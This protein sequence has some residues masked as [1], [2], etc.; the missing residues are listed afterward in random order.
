MEMM[1]KMENGRWK[2]SVMPGQSTFWSGK[3]DLIVRKVIFIFSAH[4]LGTTHTHVWKKKKSK[5]QTSKTHTKKRGKYWRGL[6]YFAQHGSIENQGSL[7][8][9]IYLVKLKMNLADLKSMWICKIG[10]VLPGT[11]LTAAAALT[12]FH[13][14]ISQQSSSSSLQQAKGRKQ[15]SKG[16]KISLTRNHSS[17]QDLFNTQ[18]DNTTETNSVWSQ[19]RWYLKA[20]ERIKL[21][22]LFSSIGFSNPFVVWD[23]NSFFY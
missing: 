11:G 15:S 8:L 5:K 14:P 16:Q 20:Q 7:M 1:E 6:F 17:V 23:T 12:V 13:L 21:L 19:E 9:G 18:Y 4:P 10:A 22:V 2:N 3:K